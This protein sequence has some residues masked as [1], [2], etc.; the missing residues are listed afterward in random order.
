MQGCP[1]KSTDDIWKVWS[2]ALAMSLHSDET[3]D[4]KSVTTVE[5]G[6]TIDADGQVQAILSSLEVTVSS[7]SE[8]ST[9]FQPP[10]HP[11]HRVPPVPDPSLS[12]SPAFGSSRLLLPLPLRLPRL[13]FASRSE[14]SV[15]S[16]HCVPQQTP[17]PSSGNTQRTAAPRP[18]RAYHTASLPIPPCATHTDERHQQA[19]LRPEGGGG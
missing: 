11:A 3:D 10:A 17:T 15:S 13:S 18:I 2:T 7:L 5:T 16:L 4:M 9:M 19:G 1:Q 8:L 6:D 14:S 12:W